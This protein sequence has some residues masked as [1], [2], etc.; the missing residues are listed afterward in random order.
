[1][2]MMVKAMASP[3]IARKYCFKASATL[4][5]Q[6][7][8][9]GTFVA[10]GKTMEVSQNVELACTIAL[11]DPDTFPEAV[12]D[13]VEIMLFEECPVE[14]SATVRWH[15]ATDDVNRI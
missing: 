11:Q 13:P 6:H 5:N 9:F 2:I 15:P 12:W 3:D 4:Y 10:Y 7:R 1:M 8:T 14:C